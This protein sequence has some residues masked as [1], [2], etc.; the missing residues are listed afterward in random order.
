MAITD[1][2]SVLLLGAGVSAPFNLPLGG[3]FIDEIYAQLTAERRSLG[4][5]EHRKPSDIGASL[6]SAANDNSQFL[7]FPIHTAVGLAQ[8]KDGQLSRA[9]VDR[10][11]ARLHELRNLL[12]G[13]TSETIDDFIVQ[14]PS[15]AD[16][17]K[18]AVATL[19]FMRCYQLTRFRQF[20]PKPLDSRKCGGLFEDDKLLKNPGLDQR[21]WIHHL[22]NIIRNSRNAE[23]GFEGRIK[24][25]TFNYDMILERVL[26][27][28][29]ANSQKQHGEWKQFI[30]IYHVHGRC[31]PID[32]ITER[33]DV[34]IRR[35]A[36]GIHV[37]N[38]A[39]V[40]ESVDRARNAARELVDLATQIHCVG[41]AFGD[42]NR[43]LLGLNTKRGGVLNYCN[44]DGNVGVKMS[45]EKCGAAPRTEAELAIDARSKLKVIENSNSDRR[46]MEV[47]DWFKIGY[48]G[49]LP[50]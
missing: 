8:D 13:Q 21:N 45:A 31:G 10:E 27:Q 18:I 5:E 3:Q 6:V 28:Q 20:V 34:V 7:K 16:I 11:M 15:L 9:D 41:F 2:K 43:A 23:C 4:V 26:T 32:D 50:G 49:P 44:Y 33:P 19:L 42:A 30:D 40:T 38:D 17:A 1:P 39:S 14:N 25:I 48:A 47:A 24:I 36:E 12:D 37:V 46:P 35:W 29:F 22:I